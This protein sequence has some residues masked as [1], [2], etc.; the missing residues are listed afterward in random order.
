MSISFQGMERKISWNNPNVIKA[1]FLLE[2][3]IYYFLTANI[4]QYIEPI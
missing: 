2:V 1:Y 3:E 4:F